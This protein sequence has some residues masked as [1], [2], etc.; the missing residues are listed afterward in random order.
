MLESLHR[1][2]FSAIAQ[3]A[4]KFETRGWEKKEHLLDSSRSLSSYSERVPLKNAFL[5]C[6]HYFPPHSTAGIGYPLYA[7]GILLLSHGPSPSLGRQPDF[8]ERTRRCSKWREEEKKTPISPSASWHAKP[9][10]I[11][12]TAILQSAVLGYKHSRG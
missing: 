5:H 4:Y 6:L 8:T 3:H 12:S 9:P 7:G 11:E 2:I 10:N 1:E